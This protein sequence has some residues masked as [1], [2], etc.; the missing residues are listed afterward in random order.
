[1]IR[2]FAP[3][4]IMPLMSEISLLRSDS[5]FVVSSL[6][7]SFVASSLIDWVSAIRN[8]FASFS[9]CAKPTVVVLRSS[10]GTPPLYAPNLHASPGTA[11]WT[12]CAAPDPAACP[13]APGA[14]LA[15]PASATTTALAP[16][17]L[18]IPLGEP[19]RMF[20]PPRLPHIS[21][22]IRDMAGGS[23]RLRLHVVNDHV[24]S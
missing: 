1:M 9:D 22:D 21:G 18:K 19:I 8:G 4:S 2:T 16:A 5:A 15:Q 17:S 7:P 20:D 6:M 13:L 11:V 23:P 3:W 24:N 14:A 10:L 12:T